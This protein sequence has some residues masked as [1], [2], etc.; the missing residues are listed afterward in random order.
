MICYVMYD[1]IYD[2]IYSGYIM[3][4]VYIILY[5]IIENHCIREKYILDKNLKRK[6]AKSQ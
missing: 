1:Y 6:S 4:S 5:D 3:D 2:F